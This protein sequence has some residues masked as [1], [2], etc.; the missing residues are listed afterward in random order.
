ML[1]ANLYSLFLWFLSAFSMQKKGLMIPID[2]F[3]GMV[4]TASNDRLLF[5]FENQLRIGVDQRHSGRPALPL[6]IG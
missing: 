3:F 1:F 2:I 4:F 5:G 6:W